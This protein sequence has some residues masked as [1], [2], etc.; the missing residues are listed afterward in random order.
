MFGIGSFM[1]VPIFA[2]SR[3]I[4]L[5]EIF[6][7]Y[8]HT[9]TELHEIVFELLAEL[10]PGAESERIENASIGN[11]QIEQKKMEAREVENNNG[12]VVRTEIAAP[13]QTAGTER[14]E[15]E[16]EPARAR[17]GSRT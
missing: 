3:I 17:K 9:F 13:A 15:I 14:E 5:V 7:P 2:D 12:A 6:S 1:A 10:V 16:T 8:P 4:G 11:E